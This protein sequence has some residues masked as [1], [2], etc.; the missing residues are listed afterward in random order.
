MVRGATAA[1]RS[2]VLARAGAT[3]HPCIHVAALRSSA[4]S[5]TAGSQPKSFVALPPCE[6]EP[7]AV[8]AA[9][10]AAGKVVVLDELSLC[11]VSRVRSMY[12]GCTSGVGSAACNH[13]QRLWHLRNDDAHSAISEAL[14]HHARSVLAAPGSLAHHLD[15]HGGLDGVG[16]RWSSYLHRAGV[17][18]RIEGN[19][20]W[21]TNP[22]AVLI[23]SHAAVSQPHARDRFAARAP[24][25][26]TRCHALGLRSLAAPTSCVRYRRAGALTGRRGWSPTMNGSS[27]SSTPAMP[28][29]AWYAVGAG[30]APAASSCLSMG[31]SLASSPSATT[32]RLPPAASST[33]L[34]RSCTDT[35]ARLPLPQLSSAM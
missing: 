23:D 19:M 15:E 4:S 24:R 3:G 13:A 5:W 22:S 12:R 8:Y 16:T 17:L 29:N 20:S 26:A 25:D 7:S 34:S 11:I 30:A 1:N 6:G 14:H 10:K 9:I 33:A 31:E 28:T 32:S 2:R 27:P 18:D 21:T 35:A